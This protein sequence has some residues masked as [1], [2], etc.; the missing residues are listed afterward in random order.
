MIAASSGCGG[1]SSEPPAQVAPR[2]RANACP[3]DVAGPRE[4]KHGSPLP[5]RDLRDDVAGG[6]EAVK[7]ERATL[8]RHHQ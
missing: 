2:R 7:T 4:G 1:S 6:A 5:A 3:A 8:A